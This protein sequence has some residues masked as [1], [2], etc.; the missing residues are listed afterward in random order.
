LVVLLFFEEKMA[1]H[2]CGF[3]ESGMATVPLRDLCDDDSK[4]L[5]L[6]MI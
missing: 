4:A 2:R 1:V 5:S 6:H 3:G